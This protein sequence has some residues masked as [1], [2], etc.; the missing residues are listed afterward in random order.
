MRT[1]PIF[2]SKPFPKAK[3]HT[4]NRVFSQSFIKFSGPEKNKP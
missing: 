4:W 1:D 3:V 2:T